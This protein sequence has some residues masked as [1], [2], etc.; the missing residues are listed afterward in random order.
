MWAGDSVELFVYRLADGAR[1][2][3][4][5]IATRDTADTHSLFFDEDEVHL[6]TTSAHAYPKTRVVRLRKPGAA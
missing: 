4:R 6:L 2:A 1:I 3:R 5:L